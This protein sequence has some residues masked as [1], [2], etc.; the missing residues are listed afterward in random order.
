MH[1]KY[2]KD[3]LVILAVNLDKNPKLAQQFL[4]Q[5]PAQF[6]VTYDPEGIVAGK[7]KIPGM[8]TSYL[9]G[10]D[11]E[12]IIAHQGFH[13]DKKASYEA[14]IIKLLKEQE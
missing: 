14:E 13:S 12:L 5:I 6:R 1:L 4:N 7:Y 8:P 2:A 3:G 10:R 11:G 9:I